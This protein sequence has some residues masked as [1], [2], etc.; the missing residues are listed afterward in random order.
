MTAPD[1][2]DQPGQ[3]D[4]HGHDQHQRVEDAIANA[5]LTA[6]PVRQPGAATPGGAQGPARVVTGAV[7][8]CL[9]LGVAML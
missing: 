3:Q 8:A 5:P 1:G 7:R 9:A 4:G 2:A 6:R